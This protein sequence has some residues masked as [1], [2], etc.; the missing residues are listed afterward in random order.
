MDDG[1]C[2]A[3]TA[4][5]LTLAS[6]TPLLSAPM[7]EI[8]MAHSLCPSLPYVAGSGTIDF[9]EFLEM[10][11]SKMSERDSREEILKAFR[12]FDDDETGKITLKNLRRVAKEIGEQ[13]TDEELQG[14]LMR[15]QDEE[16]NKPTVRSQIAGTPTHSTVFARFFSLFRDD[17]GGRSGR[18]QR[19]RPGGVPAHHEE[20][21]ALLKLHCRIGRCGPE[22]LGDSFC[23]SASQAGM[24]VCLCTQHRTTNQSTNVFKHHSDSVRV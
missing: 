20:D 21:V 23:E 12:L 19:D 2:G 13:M 10:M 22:R 17:R 1:Q 16:R 5:F 14:Q 9:N 24:F 3:H 4:P 8:P 18:R 11:T 6:P 15:K 7:V